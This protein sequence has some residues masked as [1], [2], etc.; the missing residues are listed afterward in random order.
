MV[1]HVV[2][3]KMKQCTLPNNTIKLPSR[4]SQVRNIYCAKYYS[5]QNID[6]IKFVYIH[7]SLQL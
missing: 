5:K 3:L 1:S 2:K 4:G 6:K 7:V